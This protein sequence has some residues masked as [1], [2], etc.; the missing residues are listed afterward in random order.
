M[1]LAQRAFKSELKAY[2]TFIK[3]GKNI[4]NIKVL[5]STRLSR[6]F[7]LYKETSKIKIG[8]TQIN[9]DYQFEKTQVNAERKYNNTKLQN[10]LMISEFDS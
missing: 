8:N 9:V 2:A 10:R 4:F 3:Y 1:I 5:N 6:S 7:G